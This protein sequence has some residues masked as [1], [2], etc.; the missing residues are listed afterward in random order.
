MRDLRHPATPSTTKEGQ[1]DASKVN[2]SPDQNVDDATIENNPKVDA[3]VISDFYRLV[4]AA[5][6]AIRGGR[7]ANYGLSHPLDS[8]VVPTDDPRRDE[9]SLKE[10]KKTGT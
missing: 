10:V 8:K 2:T 4:D 5:K 9:E 7:G 6:G 1:D 3:Q